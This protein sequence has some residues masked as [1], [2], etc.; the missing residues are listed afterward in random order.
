MSLRVRVSV[1]SFNYSA[2]GLSPGDSFELSA[3]G[4]TVPEGKRFCYFAITNAVAAVQPHL[5]ASQPDAYLR[6]EPVLM[7]PDTPEDLRMRVT[8][9]EEN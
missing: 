2:C 4:V 5:H 9:I 8:L 7:C 6:G 3:S 1:E